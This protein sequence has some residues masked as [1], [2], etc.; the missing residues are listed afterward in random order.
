MIAVYTRKGHKEETKTA[1]KGGRKEGRGRKVAVYNKKRRKG[2][3][4]AA[5]K[6]GRKEG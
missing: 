4:K 6:G 5:K 3:T 1:K 2:E